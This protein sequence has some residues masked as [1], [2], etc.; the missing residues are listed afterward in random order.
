MINH[1]TPIKRENRLNVEETGRTPYGQKLRAKYGTAEARRVGA[2]DKRKATIAK[3]KDLEAKTKAI[4]KAR[5]AILKNNVAKE[6]DIGRAH[7]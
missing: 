2:N 1:I 3:K 6:Q 7:Y 5:E 4:E